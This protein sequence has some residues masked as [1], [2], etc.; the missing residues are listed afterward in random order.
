VAVP[1]TMT[2]DTAVDSAPSGP[3]TDREKT[4]LARQLLVD[5]DTRRETDPGLA[6]QLTV[7]AYQLADLPQTRGAVLAATGVAAPVGD[8][9]PVTVAVSADGS[10]VAEADGTNVRV[11]ALADLAG[12]D[13]VAAL[14]VV[15]AGTGSVTFV[16]AG[17]Q[18]LTFGGDPVGRLWDL[19]DASAPSQLGQLAA[20]TDIV[21]GVDASR[22]GLR[23]VSGGIDETAV[24]WSIADPRAPAV[25]AVLPQGD[26]GPNDPDVYD[27]AI[28]PDGRLV[29]AASF[30]RVRL[31]DVAD[32]A[33]PAMLADLELPSSGSEVT[34]SADGTRLV[35][36]DGDGFVVT[37][38]VSAPAR[39]T[40]LA[41]L[42]HGNWVEAVAL[43]PDGNL[44]ATGGWDGGI[45]L[46]DVTDPTR[47]RLSASLSNVSSYHVDGL[48]FTP[49][50]RRIVGAV[51]PSLAVWELDP[52]TAIATMCATVTTPI[53][54]DQWASFAPRVPYS[55]PCP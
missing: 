23:A 49:D 40:K 26:G 25:L 35:A 48:A 13:L 3:L 10:L 15:D 36:G 52:K 43:S 9:A 53:T 50:G 14:P 24:L 6:T 55:P 18:I 41:Q 5:A 27:V 16:G 39:P 21:A 17:H 11:H 8:R 20:H 44:L 31:W 34:F 1:I 4:L 54:A 38:D 29:A 33:D 42:L 46:W 7:A 22:D 30:G 12:P 28:S 19:P 47:P 51:T 2:R 45:K 37:W 32:P